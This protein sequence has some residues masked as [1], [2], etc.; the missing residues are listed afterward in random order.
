MGTIDRIVS[1]A[2]PAVPGFPVRPVGRRYAA[3][4]LVERLGIPAE[5]YELQMLPGVRPEIAGHVLGAL[6]RGQ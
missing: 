5:G 2:I 3:R 6:V 1:A 4:D